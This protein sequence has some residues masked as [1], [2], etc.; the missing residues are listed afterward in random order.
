MIAG[1][2]LFQI[3]AGSVGTVPD[4]SFPYVLL[5]AVAVGLLAL[6]NVVATVPAHRARRLAPA[7]VLTT[8]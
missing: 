3:F 2:L 1:R 6:A 8:E 4:A 5:A 7:P